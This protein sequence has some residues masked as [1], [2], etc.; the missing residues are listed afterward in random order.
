MDIVS[1]NFTVLNTKTANR[2]LLCPSGCHT[3]PLHSKYTDVD[4]AR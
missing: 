1:A 2:I 4:F 3:H